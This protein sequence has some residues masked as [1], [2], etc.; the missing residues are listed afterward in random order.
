VAVLVFGDNDYVRSTETELL[1]TVMGL[2]SLRAMDAG[3]LQM[4]RG[5]SSA[6]QR[7]LAGDLSALAELGRSQGLE[8]LLI[9][10]LTARA[11]PTRGSFWGA[12]ADLDLK[13]Y[14]LSTGSLA[15]ARTFRA[16]ERQLVP[17]N[18]EADALR[19]ATEDVGG[20]AAAVV[21]RWM[22][23]ASR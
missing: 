1:S 10:D 15:E 9:G 22:R 21:R 14:R 5:E 7:A 18:S 17:G 16:G 19:K 13:L 12:S 8:F 20:R 11:E 3:T 4:M 2:G 23:S 6:V